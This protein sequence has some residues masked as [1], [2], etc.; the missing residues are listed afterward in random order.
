[1]PG[2]GRS[3]PRRRTRPRRAAGSTSPGRSHRRPLQKTI[4]DGKRH[5][6][7]DAFLTPALSRPNLEVRSNCQATRLIIENGK[8]VGV[9]YL[10]DGKPAQARA[11]RE[12]VLAGGVVD[13][14]KL[15][16]LS[17]IGPARELKALGIGVI[18][19]VPGVG[20]NFQDHLKLSIRWNGKTE[21]P[22]S[23]VTAGMF[24]RSIRRRG[25][26]ASLRF[27]IGRG[28]ERRQVHHHHRLACGRSR[29]EV[30]LRSGIRWRHK[31]SGELPAGRGGRD[32][33]RAA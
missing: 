8:A 27:C 32:H 22:G 12:I 26:T 11:S 20:R 9:E 30:R 19:D 10:R 17:G 21:L 33:A 24:T 6:V 7:A 2:T 28:A 13:T 4:L 25:A 31:S 23:T 14:P 5:S 1:M 16:L 15:L 29:G 18:A 3:S